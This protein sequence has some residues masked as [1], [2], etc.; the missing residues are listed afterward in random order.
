M[1]K[2]PAT[3]RATDDPIVIKVDALL[4]SL[5]RVKIELYREELFV[6]VP[7]KDVRKTSYAVMASFP[8]Y[9]WAVLALPWWECRF[10]P[11]KLYVDYSEVGRWV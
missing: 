7:E 5:A 6:Y 1:L 4:Y 9:S 8:S 3:V 11:R 2:I 10:T